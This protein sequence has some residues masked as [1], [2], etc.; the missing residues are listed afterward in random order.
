[1]HP[2]EVR[3]KLRKRIHNKRKEENHICSAHRFHFPAVG[4][5]G[6]KCSQ[7]PLT[8]GGSGHHLPHIHGK[9]VLRSVQR[10]QLERRGHRCP[11]LLK[12]QKTRCPVSHVKPLVLRAKNSSR[13]SP[14]RGVV[15]ASRVHDSSPRITVKNADQCHTACDSQSQPV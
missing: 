12:G 11:P 13:S 10:G 1:M 4:M 6:P 14:C 9:I 8:A 5:A 7:T 3:G 2:R 15:Q